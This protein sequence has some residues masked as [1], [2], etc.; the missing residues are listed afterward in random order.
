MLPEDE[1]PGEI[2]DIIDNEVRPLLQAHGGDIQLLEVTADGYVR[3]KLI[4]ACSTCPGA[5]QTLSEVVEQAL[6]KKFPQLRGV[7]PMNQVS[8]DLIQEALRILRKK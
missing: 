3:M 1:S 2:A 5:Q 8:D 6:R 7:I 4:G